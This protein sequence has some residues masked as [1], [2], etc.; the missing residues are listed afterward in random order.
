MGSIG[1]VFEY[2]ESALQGI[3]GTGLPRR[4]CRL[5]MTRGRPLRVGFW[6]RLAAPDFAGRLGGAGLQ[7]RLG[8]G[9][10]HPSGSQ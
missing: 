6:G 10:L 3:L 8:A 2:G 9:L 5:A 1:S 4:L 7:G